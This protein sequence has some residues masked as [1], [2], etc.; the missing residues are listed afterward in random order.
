MV[1]H[2]FSTRWSRGNMSETYQ[3]DTILRLESVTFADG[4]RVNYDYRDQIT[5]V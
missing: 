3:Y 2:A 4:A 5:K 1:P